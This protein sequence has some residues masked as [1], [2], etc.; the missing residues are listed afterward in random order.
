MLLVGKRKS[1]WRDATDGFE[2]YM[3]I[4][5]YAQKKPKTPAQLKNQHDAL[6]QAGSFFI[7]SFFSFNPA[8]NDFLGL[9]SPS[10]RPA[11]PER[12]SGNQRQRC[13]WKASQYGRREKPAP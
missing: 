12:P 3:A 9:M 8:I 6:V 5:I 2:P 7:Y 4:S 13:R 1:R 10:C 11:F